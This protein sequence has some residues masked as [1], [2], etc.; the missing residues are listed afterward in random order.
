M[1]TQNTSLPEFFIHMQNN[2]EP[3]QKD[4]RPLTNIECAL[5]LIYESLIE[6]L[7]YNNCPEKIKEMSL[8][9]WECAD[10]ISKELK[11]DA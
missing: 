5:S 3:D 1:S 10:D 6:I 2:K 11:H 8:A 4:N 7:T 9:I